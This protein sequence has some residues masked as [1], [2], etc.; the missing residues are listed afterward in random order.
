MKNIC[1]YILKIGI[2]IIMPSVGAEQRQQMAIL[3]H[4]NYEE[5]DYQSEMEDDFNYFNQISHAYIFMAK[6]RLNYVFRKLDTENKFDKIVYKL[7]KLEKNKMIEQKNNK[8]DISTWEEDRFIEEMCN[9][10]GISDK[11][12]I[13]QNTRNFS[14]GQGYSVNIDNF[15]KILLINQKLETGL[16]VILMG[17]T[18]CGKTYLLEYYAQVLKEN[19][20][21]FETYVLHA[22]VTE[23]TLKDF[24]NKKI[25]KAEEFLNQGGK[26]IFLD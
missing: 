3:K 16:P 17:E 19:S 8:D 5:E 21:D 24:V 12:K 14:Q 22:G 7:K 9:C 20:V 15:F 13:I 25:E 10:L 4:G 1:E 6:N 18:G 11:D 2:E 26:Y 23:E